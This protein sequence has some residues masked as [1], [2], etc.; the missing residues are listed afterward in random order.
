[1]KTEFT[2]NTLQRLWLTANDIAYENI[3]HVAY[4]CVI[5]MEPTCT[6]SLVAGGLLE[7]YN[8]H[9]ED[10]PM[11]PT[12]GEECAL[13]MQID[14]TIYLLF[15]GTISNTSY[16]AA[17]TPN[18]ITSHY[19][20]QINSTSSGLDSIPPTAVRYITNATGGENKVQHS[21]IKAQDGM[22][23]TR[24]YNQSAQHTI[25]NMGKMILD[26]LDNIQR[27]I[28]DSTDKLFSE[29]IVC[30]NIKLQAKL[31]GDSLHNYIYG[32]ATQALLGGMNYASILNMLCRELYLTLIPTLDDDGRLVMR[33]THLNP[34]SKE[35]IKLGLSDCCAVRVTGTSR[36]N[37][38]VDGIVIPNRGN[39]ETTDINF[40][41][42]YGLAQDGTGQVM[43]ITKEDL[44]RSANTKT[45]RFVQRFFPTWLH[46]IDDTDRRLT[47]RLCKEHFAQE[48]WINH[49]LSVQVPLMTFLQLRD[50]LGRVLEVPIP[51]NTTTD[52]NKSFNTTKL[53]GCLHSYTFSFT[54]YNN[55]L[56]PKTDIT[57]SHVRTE[58]QQNALAF[59]ENDLLYN[60]TRSS[61]P[62]LDYPAKDVILFD[63]TDES[64]SEL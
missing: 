9:S 16:D 1:M 5:N 38:Q 53:F 64:Y 50:Y 22:V 57:L 35:C 58:D 43:Q 29:Y 63:P 10:T 24:N 12:A 26:I 3:A 4:T 54:V 21:F 18:G 42:Y 47:T 27:G 32:R 2:T 37:N 8:Q 41:T 60:T 36:Y 6:V 45:Y 46:D 51:D 55:E 25:S 34:W 48:C 31:T 56:S 13:Y 14:D 49:H 23:A 19:S 39:A 44:H 15:G 59:N 30:D 62:F 61:I 40:Y 28:S 52:F 11:F 7:D 33:I 20:I 17:I